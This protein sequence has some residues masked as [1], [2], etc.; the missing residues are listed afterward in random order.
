MQLSATHRCFVSQHRDLEKILKLDK[1]LTPE[2]AIELYGTND[3]T[4][5]GHYDFGS[6][7]GFTPD[8]KPC[9]Y[10]PAV[11]SGVCGQDENGDAYISLYGED[12]DGNRVRYHARKYL[13]DGNDDYFY[14]NK[15]V[16]TEDG[17]EEL[18]GGK[19]YKVVET[20]KV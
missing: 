17:E 20:Q 12:E 2:L 9:E 4:F 5:G 15:W 14:E 8:G 16:E 3:A 6:Q 10:D 19:A 18:V 13:W 1:P 11:S 7:Y